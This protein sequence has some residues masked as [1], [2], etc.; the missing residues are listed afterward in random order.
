MTI[1]D[2]GSSPLARGTP[3]SRPGPAPALRFIPARAGNT[4]RSAV[5]GVR[6][7]VHPRS[8][9][10]HFWRPRL[11]SRSS[12]SSPLARGTRIC[13]VV[14]GSLL[15]FIPARAGNTQPVSPT[16]RTAAVHPRSRGEHD[17]GDRY[18]QRKTGSSPLARGTLGSGRR[19]EGRRRG[20]AGGDADGG[21]MMKAMHTS[22]AST[23]IEMILAADSSSFSTSHMAPFPSVAAA[24]G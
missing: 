2:S 16:P 1:D 14:S 24:R 18:Y 23:R 3:A 19:P 6:C 17:H 21:Q 8:R 10:E 15:R 9:G 7:S 5:A 12:G 20:A 11:L 4:S 13:S 22:T